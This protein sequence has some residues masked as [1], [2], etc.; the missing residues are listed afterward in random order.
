MVPLHQVV[1]R[2]KKSLYIWKF[3][4]VE[5]INRREKIFDERA[6]SML[7]DFCAF[8]ESFLEKQKEYCVEIEVVIQ[9]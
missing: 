4:R 6:P 2:C 8:D 7:I 1:H 3:V 5:D 9:K